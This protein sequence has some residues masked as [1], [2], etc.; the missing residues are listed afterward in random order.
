MLLCR[1][2]MT[3]ILLYQHEVIPYKCE[4]RMNYDDSNTQNLIHTNV[5]NVVAFGD[6]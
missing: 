3:E 1:Q 2:G 6:I 5:M 4:L